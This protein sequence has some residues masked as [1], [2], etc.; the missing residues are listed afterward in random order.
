ME[1]FEGI[2]FDCAVIILEVVINGLILAFD[3]GI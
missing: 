3:C 1:N 2:G